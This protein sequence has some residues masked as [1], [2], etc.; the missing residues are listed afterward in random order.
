MTFITFNTM[1][2][3]TGSIKI[4]GRDLEDEKIVTKTAGYSSMLINGNFIYQAV[5]WVVNVKL[6]TETN[7][8]SC[9]SLFMQLGSILIF[10]PLFYLATIYSVHDDFY[11]MFSI[12][13]H[14]IN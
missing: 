14:W 13:F 5:V 6:I 4:I 12:M 3:N 10:Y 9:P 11:G 1:T 7:T 2:S 8:H